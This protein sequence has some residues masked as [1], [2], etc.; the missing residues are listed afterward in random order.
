MTRIFAT[1]RLSQQTKIIEGSNE[2][3]APITGLHGVHLQHVDPQNLESA[4][5]QNG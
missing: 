5:V 3:L 2:G 4:V 1:G